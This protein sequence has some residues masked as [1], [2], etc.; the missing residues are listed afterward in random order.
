MRIFRTWGVWKMDKTFILHWLDGSTERVTGPTISSAFAMAGYG[1]GA[2][3][4]LDFY[5]EVNESSQ[6]D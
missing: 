2:I 4:A 5:E 1:G 6:K 3:S